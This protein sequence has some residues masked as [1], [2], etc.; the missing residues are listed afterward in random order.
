MGYGLFEFNTVGPVI[1]T[2]TI[3]TL[4]KMD[5][6]GTMNLGKSILSDLIIGPSES[7]QVLFYENQNFSLTL[8]IL[9]FA[10]VDICVTLYDHAYEDMED[11]KNRAKDKDDQSYV[12]C[13]CPE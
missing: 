8:F 6:L 13:Y 7:G 2:V 10:S 3:Y 1:T 9:F 12:D 4:D 11:P 5:R